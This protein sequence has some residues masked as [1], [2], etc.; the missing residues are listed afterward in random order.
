MTTCLWERCAHHG[1]LDVTRLQTNLTICFVLR[2][3][4]GVLADEEPGIRFDSDIIGNRKPDCFERPSP[5]SAER[6]PHAYPMPTMHGMQVSSDARVPLMTRR[7][8]EPKNSFPPWSDQLRRRDALARFDTG[9]PV[10]AYDLT[11][12]PRGDA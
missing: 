1:T 6:L 9:T 11:S 10:Q 3:Q 4:S 2:V 5:W 8:R 12:R 7:V